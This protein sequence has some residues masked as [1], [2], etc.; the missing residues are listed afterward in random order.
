M[1]AMI[2]TRQCSLV[3]TALAAALLVLLS[4]CAT[5]GGGSSSGKQALQAGIQQYNDGQTDAAAG[6]LY[7]AL[8]AT[9]P[10][11]NSDQVQAHKYLAFIACS[12]KPTQQ[13]HDEFHKAL[14][15]DPSFTLT[16]AEAGHPIWG[17]VFQSEKNRVTKK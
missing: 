6:N 15:L 1:P 14:S 3:A 10:L 5:F 7:S 4:G 17:P 13:C 8:S 16:P 11:S 9:P 2:K 12:S